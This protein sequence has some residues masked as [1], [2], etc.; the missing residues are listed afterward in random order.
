MKGK[1][2]L[3]SLTVVFLSITASANT[4]RPVIDLGP[5]TAYS[6]NDNGLIVGVSGGHACLFDSTGGAN[7][8]L[9]TLGGSQSCAY[10]INNN[11]KIVGA[12]EN[13]GQ[14]ACLFDPSGAGNNKDLGDLGPIGSMGSACAYSINNNDHIVGWASNG[15]G[16]QRACLFDN[17][18]NGNNKDLGT[19]WAPYQFGAI[20]YSIN[21]NDQVVG[22]AQG[23]SVDSRACFFS[24]SPGLNTDL[25]ALGGTQSCAWS[26][27]DNGKIV[28]DASIGLS[29]GVRHACFFGPLQAN[30]DLG[31]IAGYDYSCA[32]SINDN[33]QIVGYAVPPVGGFPPQ[34]L[35]PHAC[36]FDP[37]GG[38]A[39]DLNTLID[40]LSGWTL[41]RA[42]CINNNGWIV[43]YGINP[44]G[45]T[46]AYLLTPEPAT[47]LLFGLGGTVVALRRSRR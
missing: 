20:A 13:T 46:H 5:G 15:S 47:L 43:G 36:L 3:V 33:D 32:L 35:P 29:S 12:A 21:N 10:S 28:G 8:D 22:L 19:L 9:G 42:S 14:H 44:D 16:F 39:T 6:I 40:P 31:T 7:T 45:Y 41:N 4:Y 38:G 27:N 26:I 11:G 1:T 24:P 25:G 30:T 37:S 2:I 23:I 18:G 17:T 34:F